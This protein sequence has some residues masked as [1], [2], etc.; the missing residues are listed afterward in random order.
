MKEQVQ[1]CL[2]DIWLS[3]H[4]VEPSVSDNMHVVDGKMFYSFATCWHNMS[5]GVSLSSQIVSSL[6]R[7]RCRKASYPRVPLMVKR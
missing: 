1:L 2:Q 5:D 3:C 7:L 4:R 6:E